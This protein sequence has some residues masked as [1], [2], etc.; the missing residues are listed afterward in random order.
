[1]RF[2]MVTDSVYST[3][4]ESPGAHADATYLLAVFVVQQGQGSGEQW[5]DGLQG[6][7]GL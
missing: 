5:L 1:M 6:C 4:V 7:S 2:I 3:V